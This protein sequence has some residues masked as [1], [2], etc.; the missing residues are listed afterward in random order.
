MILP[1]TRKRYQFYSLVMPAGQPSLSY[2]LA[3][4][5]DVSCTITLPVKSKSNQ[6]LYF[7]MN[8]SKSS[9]KYILA[10]DREVNCTVILPLTTNIVKLKSVLMLVCETSRKMKGMSFDHR[11]RKSAVQ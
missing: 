1:L 11:N 6:S 7:V 2:L 4:H 8:V 3:D 5:Q 10:D 9:L